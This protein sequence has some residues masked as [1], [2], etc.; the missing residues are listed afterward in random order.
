[1]HQKW[2]SPANY[3]SNGYEKTCLLAVSSASASH[4]ESWFSCNVQSLLS[5]SLESMRSTAKHNYSKHPLWLHH[6]RIC[7]TQFG[8]LIFP[9]RSQCHEETGAVVPFLV[10]F[11]GTLLYIYTHRNCS[12]ALCGW[13]DSH[14]WFCYVDSTKDVVPKAHL[15]EIQLYVSHLKKLSKCQTTLYKHVRDPSLT[16]SKVLIS[17]NNTQCMQ[18]RWRLKIVPRR[19]E[20]KQTVELLC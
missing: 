15:K 9:L 7:V 11:H 5:V 18:K 16:Q 17:V 6:Q 8:V 13:S 2:H 10:Q 3:L 20:H 19:L 12:P 1:M 4:K 14:P